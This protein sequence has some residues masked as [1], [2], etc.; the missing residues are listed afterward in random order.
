M[1]APWR[2][3]PCTRCPHGV[4]CFKLSSSDMLRVAQSPF[5]WTHPGWDQTN[6][7]QGMCLCRFCCL[8]SQMCQLAHL[9][10]NWLARRDRASSGREPWLRGLS[11]MHLW[12][13]LHGPKQRGLCTQ[14]SVQKHRTTKWLRGFTLRSWLSPSFP[15]PPLSS[16]E[17]HW[18]KSSRSSRR[19]NIRC[20]EWAPMWWMW[21]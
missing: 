2:H 8:L 6:A 10:D 16:C 3:H 21:D 19:A 9:P 14:A 13:H 12:M 18:M 4:V 15:S 17:W 20:V 5:S 11:F 1:D 7:K